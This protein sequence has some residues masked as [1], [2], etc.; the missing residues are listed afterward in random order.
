MAQTVYVPAPLGDTKLA[1]DALV[2]IGAVDPAQLKLADLRRMT[3]E[4]LG[5]GWDITAFESPYQERYA[6]GGACLNSRHPTVQLLLRIAC[7]LRLAHASEQISRVDAGRMRDRLQ[8]ARATRREPIERLSQ[9]LREALD[10][11]RILGLVD[12]DIDSIPSL[13][14]DD[15]VTR[16]IVE[17][18]GEWKVLDVDMLKHVLDHSKEDSFEFGMPLS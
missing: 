9:H 4:L 3:G 5:W 13:Q 16:T 7:A 10:L 17:R 2:E 12:I 15:F 8:A 1:M 11:A 6:Y 14:P 18:D